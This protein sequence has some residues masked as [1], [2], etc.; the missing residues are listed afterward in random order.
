M[1]SETF[2]LV[3]AAMAIVLLAV[4]WTA[5]LAR[6]AWHVA[7]RLRPQ[8]EVLLA[9]AVVVGWLRAKPPVGRR[10]AAPTS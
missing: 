9:L 3:L 7:Q 4:I 6:G 8:M 2:G 1:Q 10:L 5:L